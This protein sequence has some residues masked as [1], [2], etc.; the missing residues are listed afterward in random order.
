MVTT[1]NKND[2]MKVSIAA[3]NNDNV[4]PFV[5][6]KNLS[7]NKFIKKIYKTNA[8]KPLNKSFSYKKK[9]L[10]DER[11]IE[12]DIKLRNLNIRNAREF[13]SFPQGNPILPHVQIVEDHE[14]LIIYQL[15]IHSYFN[16]IDCDFDYDYS[17]DVKVMDIL[18]KYGDVVTFEEWSSLIY[19]NVYFNE[20]DQNSLINSLSELCCCFSN[21][22]REVMYSFS[23][24]IRGKSNITTHNCILMEFVQQKFSKFK[25]KVWELHSDIFKIIPQSGS[26][27]EE[28][29]VCD[30]LS[31]IFCFMNMAFGYT[32]NA[33]RLERCIIEIENRRARLHSLAG[34]D[35]IKG[36]EIGTPDWYHAIA[37]DTMGQLPSI[38]KKC[39]ILIHEILTLIDVVMLGQHI[40]NQANK[41]RINELFYDILDYYP[42]FKKNFSEWRI[43]PQMGL[44]DFVTTRLQEKDERTSSVQLGDLREMLN[45][46]VDTAESRIE[47]SIWETSSQFIKEYRKGNFSRDLDKVKEITK[48][49]DEVLPKIPLEK[50]ELLINK[51][52]NLLDRLNIGTGDEVKDM[53]KEDRDYIYWVSFILFIIFSLCYMKYKDPV[54]MCFAGMIG[55]YLFMKT[56]F[57]KVFSSIAFCAKRIP[58]FIEMITKFFSFDSSE[59]KPQMD[60][61]DI[62]RFS[63]II[64]LLFTGFVIKDTPAASKLSEVYRKCV[65]WDRVTKNISSMLTMIIETINKIYNYVLDHFSSKDDG[66]N[67]A[68][69]IRDSNPEI[70][71]FI[72]TVDEITKKFYSL[73]Y[74]HSQSNLNQLEILREKGRTLIKG[75]GRNP[76]RVMME[77]MTEINHMIK[78][79]ACSSYASLGNRQEPVALTFVGPPGIGKSIIARAIT[80][81][82]V[83]KSIDDPVEKENFIQHADNYIYYKKVGNPYHEGMQTSTKAVVIDDANQCVDQAGMEGS[84]YLEYIWAVN[85]EPYFPNMAFELKGLLAFLAYWV[86]RTTNAVQPKIES[87]QFK[88]A[89]YRRCKYTYIVSPK[90]DYRGD[91]P[92]SGDWNSVTMDFN[93]LPKD[94]N[95]TPIFDKNALN[96]QKIVYANDGKWQEIGSPLSYDEV[97]AEAWNAFLEKRAQFEQDCRRLKDER[98]RAFKEDVTDKN[99]A[100]SHVEYMCDEKDLSMFDEDYDYEVDASFRAANGVPYDKFN[101]TDVARANEY[102][103]GVMEGSYDSRAKHFVLS[104]FYQSHNYS[105]FRSPPTVEEVYL[106]YYTAYGDSFWRVLLS[107]DIKEVEKFCVQVVLIAPK[108]NRSSRYRCIPDHDLSYYDKIKQK[109]STFFEDIERNYIQKSWIG[110]IRSVWIVLWENSRNTIFIFLGIAVLQHGI[111]FLVSLIFRPHIKETMRQLN[112]AEDQLDIV[113]NIV[114]ANPDETA[115]LVKL[116]TEDADIMKKIDSCKDDKI[117]L[118]KLVSDIV[119]KTKEKDIE[120]QSGKV[121]YTKS[122]KPQPKR[123]LRGPK[124]KVKTVSQMGFGLDS[125]GNSIAKKIIA[126]NLYEFY[127]SVNQEGT[128]YSRLGTIIFVR[129]KVALIPF[130]YLVQISLNYIKAAENDYDYGES[131]II[132]K[133]TTPTGF[134]SEYKKKTK[135]LLWNDDETCE[136]AGHYQTLPGCSDMCMILLDFCNLHNQKDITEH[137][138][139]VEQFKHCLP[140]ETGVLVSKSG[141]EVKIAN[142]RA[143][144]NTKS[145]SYELEDYEFVLHNSFNYTCQTEGGDCGSPLFLEKPGL[146][147]ARIFGVHVSGNEKAK[148]GFSEVVY[149]E[150]IIDALELFDKKDTI[151]EFFDDNIVYTE[152]QIGDGQFEVFGKIS[153]KAPINMLNDIIKSPLH[154]RLSYEALTKPTRLYDAFGDG[155]NVDPWSLNLKKYCKNSSVGISREIIDRICNQI[156]TDMVNASDTYVLNDVLTVEEASIGCDRHDIGKTPRDTSRGYPDSTLPEIPGLPKSYRYFGNDP[157]EYDIDNDH[158]RRLS[159]EVEEIISKAKQGVRGNHYVTDNTK[160]ERLGIPKIAEKGK[161]RVFNAY[162]KQ[163]FTAHK[164]YYGSFCDWIKKN[165]IKNCCAIGVNPYSSEWDVLTRMLL[166]FGG[167]NLQNVGA[168]DYACFDGSQLL[169]I[170][171]GIHENIIC[172][173]YEYKDLTVRRV[174]FLEMCSSEHIRGEIVYKWKGA[175]TSGNIMTTELNCLYN[176][177][178]FYY[179]WL[180]LHDFGFKCLCLFH[181]YVQLVV[182]GD[183]NSYTVAQEFI[184]IFTEKFVSDALI[185]IGLIYT[186]ETKDGVNSGMRYIT[187]IEFLKRKFV[188]DNSAWRWVAPLRLN[189]VL[190]EFYWTRKKNS[191]EERLNIVKSNVDTALR[192]LALHGPEV[193]DKYVHEINAC[194]RLVLNWQSEFGVFRFA[195]EAVLKLEGWY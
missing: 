192:E 83:G 141:A 175:N 108:F 102:L 16:M 145:T 20:F 31:T 97:C 152:A 36:L 99:V 22:F 39:P 114:C 55:T 12:K 160:G 161:Q 154:N 112:E 143:E 63:E 47:P 62:D 76:P 187:E 177:F 179:A 158:F 182:Y 69:W 148:L 11:L 163:I 52:I 103:Q 134:V 166:R 37:I 43:V 8:L 195:H 30:A 71:N 159:S 40:N 88:E 24:Y 42:N 169:D 117:E 172:R 142:V 80:H 150:V 147:R 185:D 53:K 91:C 131:Y 184:G 132:I 156:F 109:I 138:C 176:I 25:N 57:L 93:K 116:V 183:D 33:D 168:G 129:G 29:P 64:G 178:A 118:L 54:Y 17:L 110:T 92:V 140:I 78:K 146:K 137:F 194:T 180:K 144:K 115:L 38:L 65:S 100:Q 90:P 121:R 48:I 124:P 104:R 123:I 95:D 111:N 101:K 170:M 15:V 105:T 188:F 153:P 50:C 113:H 127:V 167:A 23:M 14:I 72:E 165:K 9:S 174:L 79:M 120:I 7:S 149:K 82:L 87:I 21:E 171:Q 34:P 70:Q 56:D 1:N 191:R 58:E 18:Q 157:Q 61:C 155:T 86:V 81:Y 68:R 125:N 181:I 106:S 193:F 122:N 26:S 98:A 186:S 128:K 73:R 59:T 49:I 27:S 46:I 28:S 96:F 6:N 126:S 5:E 162:S 107:K 4:L 130:H 44:A 151:V 89:Y 135:E 13:K 66:A 32:L 84:E 60:V 10:A 94:E 189:V 77:L 164:M 136:L 67:Y 75:C 173:W 19:N 41:I 139:S 133:H 190:E 3:A 35:N 85:S 45:D 119:N 74:M 2:N 51:I